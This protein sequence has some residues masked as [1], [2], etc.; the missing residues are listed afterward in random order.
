MKPKSLRRDIPLSILVDLLIQ[1][2]FVMTILWVIAE[3]QAAEQKAEQKENDSEIKRYIGDINKLKAE[4]TKLKAEINV[5]NEKLKL[6]GEGKDSFFELMA[7]IKKENES[8]QIQLTEKEGEIEKLKIR[9]GLPSCFDRDINEISSLKYYAVA[10]SGL[11]LVKP[12]PDYD[13]FLN[14]VSDRFFLP[15]SPMDIKALSQFNKNIAELVEPKNCKL[16]VRFFAVTGESEIWGKKRQNVASF[17]YTNTTFIY[18][19]QKKSY[20]QDVE[21]MLNKP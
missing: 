2:V 1:I 18:E 7:S 14:F 17:F 12:G 5:L 8:L 10:G 19:P 15:K 13:N 20:I 11:I 4:I 6:V 21:R 9:A 16:R 3:T